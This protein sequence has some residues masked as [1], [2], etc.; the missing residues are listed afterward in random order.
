[1][2]V[3]D[4]WYIRYRDADGVVRRE[5]T[6]CREK[7]AAEKFL[8][9][10][11]A[12]M[13]K[14]KTGIITPEEQEVAEHSDLPLA[15]H[16][17]AYLD[18]LSRKRIRGWKVSKM[19]RVN[20]RI[21]LNCMIEECRFKRIKHITRDKVERWLDTA[22]TEKNLAASTRNEYLIS[23]SAFC[24]WAVKNGRMGRNPLLGIGKADR[25]ADRRHLRRALTVDEVTALLEATRHRPIAEVG[26]PSMK[27]PRET[28]LPKGVRRKRCS[29]TFEPLTAE[30]FQPCYV[31][32]L[33]RLAKQAVRR[34]RLE[35]LGRKRAMFY[36]L[37]VSTGFRHNELASLTV[38][39]LHLDAQPTPYLTLSSADTKNG[40]EAMLP[41]RPDVVKKLRE[42]LADR[43]AICGASRGMNLDAKLFDSPP[44][45]RIFD[46]D[47]QAAGI[48][49]KD[50][51]N[52][53]ADI[54]ALR[55]TFG[56]HLSASGVH[57]RT[58]MAAMRHS[59]IELTMNLYT[60]PILLDVAGAVNALPN[61]IAPPT[62]K[63][64]TDTSSP[65]AG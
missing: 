3:S 2:F 34:K 6:G 42:Y 57:P 14:I 17:A 29:W 5:S 64:T 36:L 28:S 63:P 11:L 51:R 23:L 65:A 54:H 46:A 7:Q 47:L 15:K 50:A 43:Q 13:E 16:V 22:E 41:L 37:A 52:R 9:D 44:T 61:F 24:T 49:K 48:A 30:N 27:V 53:V 59:R 1:M 31:T 45:I 25:S 8:A 4:C 32:G 60:D 56:T 26:R 38:G 12:D 39:Q 21:R 58:T 19:Y 55:H 62:E 35:R 20:L 18:H 10:K 33:E 40:R